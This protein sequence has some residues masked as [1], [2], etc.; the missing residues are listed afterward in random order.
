[1][2]DPSKRR[3]RAGRR[4][5]RFLS[6]AEK[7]QAFVQ[8]LTGEMTVAQCAEHWGVDR[9]TIMKAREVAKQGALAA[10]AASR[11]GVRADGEDLELLAARHEI[12]RLSEALK[13]MAV[14]VTLLEGKERWG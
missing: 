2:P 11:P 6:P 3:D 8:V 12:A 1:M 9:S 7:Y 4:A 13:E 14:K 5:K 10:L